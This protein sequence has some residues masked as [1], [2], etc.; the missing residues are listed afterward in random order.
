MSGESESAPVKNDK[1]V[2]R[3]KDDKHDGRGHGDGGAGDA[4]ADALAAETGVNLLVDGSF[5]T[6]Q[7]GAGKWT[8]FA[9]VGGW[10][11][12]SGVEIWGKNFIRS[13]SDGDKVMELDFDTR[14]S[15]V[16][17]DVKTEAGAA[18][19]FAFDFAQRPDTKVGTNTIEVWWNG[20]RVGVV[21][22]MTTDW[23]RAEFTVK[24]TGGLDRIEFR[25]QAG[26]N[27]SYGGVIDNVSLVRAPAQDDE[28]SILLK[29]RNVEDALTGQAMDGTNGDD[30]MSGGAGD[31]HIRGG[32]GN[33]VIRGDAVGTFTVPLE[34]TASISGSVDPDAV[35]ILIAN[36]P[37]GA[38]L[39]AGH[40]NGDGTWKLAGHELKGL[41]ITA[42][43]RCDFA[44][45]VMAIATDGSGLSASEAL[46][47]TLAAGNADV[48]EGGRGADVIYGNAGDDVIYGGSKPTGT[49][50]SREP[51]PGDDDTIRAGAGDDVVFA[52]TGNDNV[53]G[54]KGH[55]W[56]SGG[57]GDDRLWG[58][59]GGDVVNGNSGDDLIFGDAGDDELVGGWGDDQLS[60]GN[61]SDVL[62]GGGDDDSFMTD[63]G[64]DE[65]FGGSGFDTL[66]LG[67]TAGDVEGA[68]VDLSAGFA[69]H[70]DW[71]Y[72][73]LSSIEAVVGGVG[74]DEIHGSTKDNVIVGG[75]GDDILRGGAGSDT[76]TGGE[77]RDVFVLLGKDVAK[78]GGA[79]LGTDVI[80][81]L[82]V[83]DV[84]DVSDLLR[85]RKAELYLK[86]DGQNSYLMAVVKGHTVEVAVL[87][88]FSGRTLDDMIKDG[89]LLV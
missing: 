78:L 54:G 32:K 15:R 80:T 16:W 44:L 33:D 72:D 3:K 70:G 22:P 25:E 64:D 34:I 35:T 88:D 5:E 24:G 52:G 29:T 75:A 30:E 61:G 2:D 9:S 59:A 36:V 45:K 56:I 60:G 79:S 68:Y 42:P 1:K 65:I 58:G 8:S 85:T 86:D 28:R 84:V 17:Q 57:R 77:G 63:A 23:S 83:G 21:D 13:A 73:T 40:D 10:Q 82:Q 43:D 55:D 6:A 67:S 14:D 87:E 71:G 46:R 89:M 53:W 31:D 39:S 19:T 51:H 49:A 62:R 7:I 74:N 69:K 37:K 48:I 18:Y 47:V 81:D 12:D 38:T 20:E 76:L 11:S 27:D 66:H 50:S 41:E 26:D 4:T